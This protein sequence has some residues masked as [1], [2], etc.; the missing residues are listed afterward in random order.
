M[1][2]SASQ[3]GCRML[4][5]VIKY[6]IIVVWYYICWKMVCAQ[7][8]PHRVH[9]KKAWTRKHPRTALESQLPRKPEFQL[10]RLKMTVLRKQLI[11]ESHKLQFTQALSEISKGQSRVLNQIEGNDS[12]FHQFLNVCNIEV[13]ACE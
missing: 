6:V 10:S 3:E 7:T 8:S 11:M 4:S 12:F 13:H 9:R 1:S 2:L 5:Y